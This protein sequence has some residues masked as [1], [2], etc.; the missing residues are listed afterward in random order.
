MAA[1]SQPDSVRITGELVFSAE[2]QT[3][4]ACEDGR[5]YWVRVLAANPHHT[6]RVRFD[7][8]SE[9]SDSTLAV[10]EGEVAAVP[11]RRPDYPV[12]AVLQ[13]RRTHSLQSGD[14]TEV[15]S[16]P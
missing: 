16:R 13:V 7:E 5:V 11:S 9:S 14:C 10:L 6:M 1:C 4:T 3:L 8:L 2:R 15:T 12:E